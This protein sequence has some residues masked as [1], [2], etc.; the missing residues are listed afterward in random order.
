MK[1]SKDPIDSQ[2][3]ADA[4]VEARTLLANAESAVQAATQQAVAAKLQRKEAKQAASL[5]KKQ[6]KLAR[7]ERA[8]AKDA[9]S[10]TEK[11]LARALKREAKAAQKDGEQPADEVEGPLAKEK[12]KKKKGAARAVSAS[13]VEG[14]PAVPSPES[15]AQS[16]DST[17]G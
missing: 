16:G 8:E 17:R 13:P 6:L 15:S 14:A 2:K 4:A 3:L 11:K 12:K 7:K 9:V 1:N 5:A 10:K